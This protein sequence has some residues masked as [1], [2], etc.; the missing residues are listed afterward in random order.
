V[1]WPVPRRC[2]ARRL[3]KVG[4]FFPTFS[5]ILFMRILATYVSIFFLAACSGRNEYSVEKYF[6]PAEQDT[7]LADITT[8]MYVMPRHATPE[9]RF[10]PKFRRYYVESSRKFRFQKYFIG[11]DGTHYFYI[12]RP[13]RSA[14]SNIRGVGG[15]LRLDRDNHIVSFEEV[16]NTPPAD[17][18]ILQQRGDRLFKELIRKGNVNDYLHHPDYIEWPDKT[19]YYDTATHQWLLKPGT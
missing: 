18:D 14:E 17:L 7:L 10:D 16:F 4:I 6:S 19:T 12:I 11:D 1:A 2:A 15:K 13:A 8:Y 9:S 5:F 3:F